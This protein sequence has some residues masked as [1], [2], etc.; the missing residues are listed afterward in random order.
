MGEKA[1]VKAGV[2]KKKAKREDLAWLYE[3]PTVS[4]TLEGKELVA[5]SAEAW[6]RIV[7]EM[8]DYHD[9][10]RARAS[11]ADPKRKVVSLEEARREW[12]D[13][14]IKKVRLRKGVTQRELARRLGCTQGWVSQ[15]EKPDHRPKSKT[16]K[17]VAEALDCPVEELV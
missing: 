1:M 3:E 14:N 15:I 7:E 16:Y 9:L 10:K 17:R 13:N 8:E 12:F 5:V 6:E 2:Q 11:L 4:L